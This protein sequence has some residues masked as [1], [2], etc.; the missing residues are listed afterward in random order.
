MNDRVVTGLA[1]PRTTRSSQLQDQS[2][3]VPL[4][5]IPNLYVI[6]TLGTGRAVRQLSNP[7]ILCCLHV[8]MLLYLSF[9][10]D[11]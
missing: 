4:H 9:T 5:A 7:Y 11:C 6:A 10:V 3:Q 2:M 1:V 8:C